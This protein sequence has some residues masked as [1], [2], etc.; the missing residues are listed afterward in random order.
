[1]YIASFEAYK[2]KS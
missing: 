2:Y 1:M